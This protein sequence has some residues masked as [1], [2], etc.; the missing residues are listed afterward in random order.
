MPQLHVPFVHEAPEQQ[1]ELFVQ[2]SATLMQQMPSAQSPTEV[3]QSLLLRQ[4]PPSPFWT[5]VP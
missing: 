4:A 1:S 3:V 5:H 2:T